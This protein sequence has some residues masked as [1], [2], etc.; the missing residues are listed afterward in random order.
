METVSFRLPRA[1]QGRMVCCLLLLIITNSHGSLSHALPH[2]ILFVLVFSIFLSFVLFFLFVSFLCFLSCSHF[3]PS[4]LNVL[5]SSSFSK[6][7]LIFYSLRLTF[8]LFFHVFS[9]SFFRFLYIFYFLYIFCVRIFSLPT[10]SLTLRAC[11]VSLTYL[12]SFFFTRVGFR[13]ASGH[14][15]MQPAGAAGGHHGFTLARQAS[16]V[17]DA[18]LALSQNLTDVGNDKCKK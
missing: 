12:P 9:S 5:F 18:L 17:S 8:V 11:S 15:K 16:R 7:S 10:T 1:L 2:G 3:A 6:F 13:Q 4:P 14:D